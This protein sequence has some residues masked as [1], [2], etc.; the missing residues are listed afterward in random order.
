MRRFE[1]RGIIQERLKRDEQNGESNRN[2]RKREGQKG[3]KGKGSLPVCLYLK[4]LSVLSFWIGMFFKVSPF[5]RSENETGNNME[6]KKERMKKSNLE[7]QKTERKKGQKST[8]LIQFPSHTHF[9]F[10]SLSIHPKILLLLSFHLSF[11]FFVSSSLSLS[12]LS[13]FFPCIY[14][15]A[16]SDAT[17]SLGMQVY[18]FS[19]FFSSR[20]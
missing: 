19:I 9:L 16:F 14:S 11:P 3:M 4:R 2:D 18:V 5:L 7:R 6:R 15:L 8:K 17:F 1:K 12:L 13:T 10:F 20:S